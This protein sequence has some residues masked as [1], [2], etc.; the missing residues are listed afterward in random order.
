MGNE[1]KIG[2]TL[3]IPLQLRKEDTKEQVSITINA[4]DMNIQS[5]QFRCTKAIHYWRGIKFIYI[6]NKDLHQIDGLKIKFIYSLVT[7]LN[8]FMLLL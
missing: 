3:I 5:L 4:G 7:I 6:R 2:D 1:S 8:E